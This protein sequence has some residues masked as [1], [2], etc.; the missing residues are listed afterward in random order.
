M[1]AQ[2]IRVVLG[3][4][5]FSWNDTRVASAILAVF[6]VGLVAQSLVQMLI[7]G[8][9]A[10]GDAKKTLY[11]NILSQGIVVIIAILLLRIFTL[12]PVISFIQSVLRLQGVADIRVLALPFAFA[13]GNIANCIF[14]GILFT[15]KF[16]KIPWGPMRRSFIQV[17]IA[18]LGMASTA[19][20]MLYIGSL[21]LNQETFLGILL[22]GSIAGIS[23]MIVWLI[24]LVILKNQDI[25]DFLDVLKKRFWKTK[26]VQDAIITP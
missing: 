22:Q 10:M 12:E 23:G 1:R 4:H 8:M 6:M 5:S 26:V 20:I 17:L 18:T 25:S 14:L 9:Y 11:T 19:Y 2:I 3:T 7:R 15:K 13:I 16:S 21:F 24:L